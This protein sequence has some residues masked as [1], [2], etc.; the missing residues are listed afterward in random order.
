MGWGYDTRLEEL[1]NDTWHS[2]EDLGSEYKG[3][4]GRWLHSGQLLPFEAIPSP[5][6]EWVATVAALEIA[7]WHDFELIVHTSRSAKDIE[8]F[9]RGDEPFPAQLKAADW[10]RFE[11]IGSPIDWRFGSLRER[12]QEMDDSWWV[13]MSYK[14]TLADFVAQLM[15]I[16]KLQPFAKSEQHRVSLR[17]G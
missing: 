6:G 16:E 10:R 7:T 3:S 4:V 8:H 9:E 12:R 17:F 1:S 13:L 11:A 5:N 15:P 14:T 2:I